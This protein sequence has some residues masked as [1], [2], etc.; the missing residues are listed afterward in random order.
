[1]ANLSNINGKFVVE[2]TTGYVGIGITDPSQLLHLQSTADTILKIDNI[3]SGTGKSYLLQS[4]TAGSFVIRDED[5]SSNRLLIDTSG[6][7]TFV[8]D[9]NITNSKLQ[10]TAAA[11]EIIFSVPSGGL[12]SRIYNDGSGNFIIGHG[13]NS[14]TPTTAITIDS[15][16]N[17]TFA[18]T[19]TAGRNLNL[20]SSDYTYLQGTHT[21]AGDGDYL[22][23]TFGYGDSTFYGSFDILKHD[24]DDGELRLRQRIA[25]TATDVLSI[26]DGNATFAGNVTVSGGNITLSGTG[27]IQGVDTVSAGTDAA[28]KAYVDTTAG[29]YLPLAGGTMTGNIVMGDNDITGIDQLI[30]TSGTFLTDVSSNYVKLHYASTAAG[31]MIILD[32]DGTTQGYLYADGGA[33]SNFGLLHGSGSWAVRCKELAEVELRYNNSVKLAT[34]STG[35]TVSGTVS[36]TTFSGDL[37]GTIN[38]VTTATTKGNST[39]DTTVATT[40]FVQNVI[41]TIPAGLVFQGTWNASTNTPTLTSGSGTTGNFYIVSVAGSTNLDGITDW[42]VGDWAVFIEQGASD[43]WE[44]IDNSSVLSGSGTGGSFAG[45]SGSGTSVTLGNAPVTF[46]GNNSTFAGEVKLQSSNAFT[47]LRT[48]NDYGWSIYANSSNFLTFGSGATANTKATSW[49]TIQDNNGN[50]T[51]AGNVLFDGSGVI[52][53][54]T[55]DGSDNAQLSLA[56]GG[57][58]SDG[59]G[60]R[61]RLYGNEHASLAGVVDLSTGNIA[62]AD[63]YLSATDSMILNTG[64]SESMRINSSGNVGIV[65]TDTNSVKL[66]ITG[67]SGLPA[68]SGTTQTGLL[69]LKASNNATLDMGADHINAV[70]WLQVTDVANLSL[71]YN[72]LL[73][74]NGGNVGIGLTSPVNKLGI[75]VAANSNTKAINIYSKNTSPNSYTSIGSQYSISNTYVES[76]IRFGNETQN[77]GGSYL[78]FVAGGTNSGNTE[79]MRIDS[80]G[81]VSIPAYADGNKFTITSSASSHHN[82][83]EMGQLGSDGFLDVSAAGGGIVSHLSGYT[84]YASYFLSN[85]GI[86]T[87]SPT[88]KFN[89]YISATRQLTHN[90]NGGDLSIISDNNS[91]PVMFIKGTG[92][93]DLLNVFDNTTEVFTILDGGNVGIGTTTPNSKL[94]VSGPSTPSLANGENSIRIERHSS[95]AASPGVIGNGINFAQKWWSGSAGLQVTGGIYGI[96]NASNG[97]YGGGLAFYTQPSSATDMEQRMVIDTSGNVGIGTTLPASAFGFSKTLEI[98][99]AANA[100]V[101]ISQTDNNKDWSLGIVNGSNYQQTTSGQAYVWESGGTERMRIDSSGNVSVGT[102]TPLYLY[103]EQDIAQIAVNRVPSTGVITDTS[104]SAAYINLNASNGGS[105]LTFH[106]ANANNTAPTERVRI[107]ADGTTK[108]NANILVDVINNSANSANIIYRS[109]TTTIVGGGSSSNKLYVLDS[110]NVGI[111]TTSPAAPLAVQ[112]NFTANG[113]YTTSNWAKYIFLDAENTGGGGIIWTKQSSTYNRAILNNQGKF[114]IG[115]S[116][117]NDNSGAWLSDLVID[118]AGNVGIGTTAPSDYYADKLV[119]KC[120]SSENGIT[121][122]SNSTTDANYLMFADGTS[123]S[124]RYRGQIKYNHQDN[125]MEFATDASNVMKI[126]SSGNVGINASASLRFNGAGDNTHAVGYDSTIDGSFLRGQLGMRFLTGTGGGSERMRITSAGNVGIG[127]TAPTSLSVNTSSLSVNS[128]RTDLS[129]ALF[130]KSNGVIKF[131]QYW[132]TVGII[133]DVSAG[134]YFWKLANVNKMGLDTGTGALTVVG[135]IVAYGSPSD[136]R[137]KENIKPI[138]SALDKVSKLQGVTFDWK[139]IR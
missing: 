1:M 43:Q 21:G 15:S 9:V 89:S 14:S 92:S 36:A 85:V 87:T 112:A 62:G 27:R 133:A 4:T 26:V 139:R 131:Q 101:N 121:I 116:T 99:G 74:P 98:Q 110:G 19:V 41:G 20:S 66:G 126:D 34:T 10:I 91:S 57:A 40:A 28:N 63:M 95:A 127:D 129:G 124:D 54:N 81:L 51:F 107:N 17:T 2:Q 109:G 106:T 96:K 69:R 65:L 125:Y 114:E 79:K 103:S 13:T 39:N 135:D 52:S 46:S 113:G 120:S 115:R 102:D 128:T 7:A 32:G 23:R 137:L 122:A 8:G 111:G 78:G 132:A 31:G 93:A 35:V 84:G 61:M 25:G 44:K 22:M 123:G 67:N 58:D 82:I 50:A 48:G 42:Q 130:Q 90:G 3:T 24:T 64:G 16:R 88:G 55:S 104:R 100:E 77:G 59:R 68:T 83:I 18:G 47:T 6:N 72:L 53:T 118:A 76:E 38:T 117:A 11:P 80:S 73:Q 134:D 33:T 70:G 37:N 49:L 56:G 75:E 97:T 71:E 138:E 119:V 86:G 12:D 105:S 136:K 30:F 45:W 94:T 108:F 5:A 29:A 60:A